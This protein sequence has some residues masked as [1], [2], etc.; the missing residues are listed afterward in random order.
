MRPG[1]LLVLIG[2]LAAAAARAGEP[3]KLTPRDLD[4]LLA[5]ELG[6]PVSDEQFLRRASLDL[7]GRPPSPAEQTAF[8]DDPAADKRARAID[9]LLA[10]KDYGRNWANYWSD[11][12]SF[13]VPPPELTF[14]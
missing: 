8:R 12:V 9:R 2:I 6:A 7:I 5:K 10:S 1:F 4:A 14:L 3:V 13:R 11:A